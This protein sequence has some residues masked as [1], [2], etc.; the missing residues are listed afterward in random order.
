M[1]SRGGNDY[2]LPVSTATGHYIKTQKKV[3]KKV[4]N[5][6]SNAAACR[7]S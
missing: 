1:F 7:I 4:W 3:K 2:F 6:R 5:E